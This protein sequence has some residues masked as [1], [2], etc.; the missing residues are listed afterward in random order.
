[1]NIRV[2]PHFDFMESS[3]LAVPTQIAMCESWPQLWAT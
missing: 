3:A 2:P 1:M